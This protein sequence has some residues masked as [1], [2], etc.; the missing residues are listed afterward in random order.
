MQELR[1]YI[2]ERD[3]ICVAWRADPAHE[4]RDRWGYPHAPTETYLLTLAHVPAANENALGKKA[5]DDERHAV[6]E[7][8]NANAGVTRELRAYERAYLARVEPG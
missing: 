1:S 4:C 7:C 2:F 5:P 6:A 8:Y 3:Q